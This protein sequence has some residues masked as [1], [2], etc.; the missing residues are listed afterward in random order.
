MSKRLGLP[1]IQRHPKRQEDQDQARHELNH[2]RVLDRHQ[3]RVHMAPA[4]SELARAVRGMQGEPG[5]CAAECLRGDVQKGA[6]EGDHP[7]EQRG[8]RDGWADVP[9]AGGGEGVDQQRGQEEV[10]DAAEEGREEGQGVVDADF[11][12]G[13]RDGG[14]GVGDHPRGDEDVHH[15]G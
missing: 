10:D 3:A 4:H 12:G 5:Q 9:A 1:R 6:R 11:G 15:A 7:R 8:Q 13:R 2:Q 14:W